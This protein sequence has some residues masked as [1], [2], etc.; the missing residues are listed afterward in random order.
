MNRQPY[1]IGIYGSYGGMNLG[2]EAILEV[3][4]R[5]LRRRFP[6]DVTV[7][8][9][10]PQDTLARHP[11]ERAVAVRQ[12][13]RAEMADV[14]RDLDLFIL[15]GGGILF[16]GEASNFVR[17]AQLAHELNVPVMTWA[18]GAG[19]LKNRDDREAV[20]QT[21]ETAAAITVR[22]TQS[23]LLLEEIGITRDITV[24]ADP[25]L[26]LEA[27]P[28]T[29]EMLVREGIPAGTRLIGMSLREPGP[30]APDLYVEHYHELIANTVDYLIDRMEAT[31]L[32]IPM[33]RRLDLQHAHSV[34][35]RVAN[36]QHVLIL[37]GEY[38]SRQIRG[39]MAHLDFAIG[40]R[41]HF[42]IFAAS[43]GTPFVSLPYGSKIAEFVNEL[44]VP[45][46]P[47]QT[48]NTGQLLATIDR[49][50]DVRTELCSRISARLAP[51]LERAT[52][53]ADLATAILS[54]A[55]TAEC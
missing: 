24:T 40:M 23:R 48:T 30:A 44:D 3:I 53:T 7:F 20:Q 9:M 52:R 4:I 37:K 39:L 38:T 14:I 49:S 16:D 51:L 45:M 11:V 6:I 50:W 28:F 22:D 10:D 27:A 1:R 12:I 46:P 54:Q 47:I 32:F 2:D 18:V 5:E 35:A 36:V 15:G 33:E 41:L 34:A 26:L 8:S 17:P 55:K 31:V 21:L 19:P 13:S 42:L 29:A 43:A 25:G